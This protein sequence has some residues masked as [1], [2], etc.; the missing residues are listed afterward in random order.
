MAGERDDLRVAARRGAIEVGLDVAH[1]FAHQDAIAVDQ[2]WPLED[3]R[4]IE[5][6]SAT[7]LVFAKGDGG[8]PLTRQPGYGAPTRYQAPFVARLS[9]SARF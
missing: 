7:D 5:G 2:R 1:A 4:P 6:G 8:R 9:L 3:T